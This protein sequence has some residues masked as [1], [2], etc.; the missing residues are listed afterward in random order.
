MHMASLS[1]RSGWCRILT[2]RI[3]PELAGWREDHDRK[4][5]ALAARVAGLVLSLGVAITAGQQ[6]VAWFVVLVLC[7][8][9]SIAERMLPRQHARAVGPAEALLVALA[10]AFP[11]TAEMPLL[12]YL[13]IPPVAAGLRFGVRW[14][15]ISSLAQAIGVVAGMLVFQGGISPTLIVWCAT[16]FVLGF[17]GGLSAGR[18]G[19]TM[20]RIY[21]S[22][23]SEERRRLSR[24]LHDGIA[25][26]LAVLGYR[27]DLLLL[28]S[29][30][31][32]AHAELAAVGDD[33][34]RVLQE[35]RWSIHDLRGGRLPEVGLGTALADHVRRSAATADMTAHL[36]LT[37]GHRKLPTPVQ[38]ELLRIAQ[39]A[40]T[41]ARKHSGA[42]N[43]WVELDVSSTAALLRVS[44]DGSNTS[45][46]R[47]GTAMEGLGLTIMR[48]R[49]RSIGAEFSYHPRPGG[50]TVV[51]TRLV[52]ASRSPGGLLVNR[53]RAHGEAAASREV[54]R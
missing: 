12:V 35:T 40:V 10:A 46:R 6:V 41:N 49:A 37:E 28:D 43:L 33:I 31:P 47:D 16:G 3:G 27:V 51:E 21:A 45:R 23:A 29:T 44:D 34:R 19:L 48:E 54:S 26:D 1:V 30:Q 5:V 22:A 8:T 9:A 11:A 36:K 2:T 25:Q 53:P 38:L 7:V 17:I 24:E 18:L 42:R 15:A 13:L 4:D 32:I 39:E 52:A 14:A 50:G 20:S